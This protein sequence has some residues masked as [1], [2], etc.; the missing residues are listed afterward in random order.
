MP[1]T[2]PICQQVL[3]PGAADCPHCTGDSLARG[4]ILKLRYR[5]EGLIG[6]GGFG[7]TYRA[8]DA[9]TGELVAV[10]E[11][12]PVGAARMGRDVL[13]SAVLRLET[14]QRMRSGFL[15]VHRAMQ[16]L[17]HRNLLAVLDVFEQH[18]TAYV[19]MPLLHGQTLAQQVE[20]RGPLLGQ[21]ARRVALEAAAGLDFLHRAGFLHRDL[22]PDNVFL[23]NDGRVVLIDFDSVRAADGSETVALTR[24]VSPGYAPL[25]Q[26]SAE[27]RFSPAADLY[28]LGA[29]LYYAVQ[30]EAPP[31]ATDLVTGSSLKGFSPTVDASLA[32]NIRSAMALK[33]HERPQSAQDFAALLA[34]P[35][36]A[37]N[38]AQRAP[39]VIKAHS[40]SVTALALHP[41]GMLLTASD[42]HSVH[43]WRLAELGGPRAS[44][45]V[46]HTHDDAVRSATLSETYGWVTAGEDGSVIVRQMGGTYPRRFEHEEALVAVDVIGSRVAAASTDRTVLVWDLESGAPL[47]RSEKLPHWP[48]ALK[49]GPQGE[50][51]FAGLQNGRL[52][53]L[54]GG[55]ARTLAE[56]VAHAGRVTALAR[57]DGLL[58]SA[59]E[60]GFVRWWDE[61]GEQQHELQ[62]SSGE[63]IAMGAEDG[64]P[65]MVADAAG[66][67]FVLDRSA[68]RAE[69]VA[70]VPGMPTALL[71]A[72]SALV[73]GLADGRVYLQGSPTAP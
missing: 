22:K 2:C 48:T 16:G 61:H 6:R 55:S 41:D 20:R 7:L 47:G 69:R 29:T 44:L 49:F 35:A 34:A 66:H 42:D 32:A 28:A 38:T 58:L 11:L 23:G 10:K 72:P 9:H 39:A 12:Y 60:D 18:G 33:A 57:H 4:L 19:V 64:S 50:T 1:L 31:S 15:S 14:L 52:L 5:L 53:L 36:P 59:G 43:L 56:R 45:G 62:V 27:Y 63:L 8:A 13:P 71:V 30:G 73:V 68:R 21:E 26:Y 65:A 46:S 24:M 3:P 17:Q 25:E 37:V 70:K 67:L 40:G 51:L 54:R